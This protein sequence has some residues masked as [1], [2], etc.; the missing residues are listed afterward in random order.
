[1]L[2]EGI[3]SVFMHSKDKAQRV[4]PSILEIPCSIFDIR[5]H[6]LRGCGFHANPLIEQ[7]VLSGLA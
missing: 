1:M 6:Q 4:H 5:I 7:W 2:N 3:L